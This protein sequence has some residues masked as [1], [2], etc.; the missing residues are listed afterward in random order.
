[1][2]YPQS[3]SVPAA[4]TTDMDM[5]MDM[6]MGMERRMMDHPQQPLPQPGKHA[7]AA[8]MAAAMAEAANEM[9]QQ[10]QHT[11]SFLNSNFNYWNQHSLGTSAA[12]NMEMMM[13][14]QP[15]PPPPTTNHSSAMA[16]TALRTFHPAV[17]GLGVYPSWTMV[18]TGTGTGTAAGPNMLNHQYLNHQQL[19]SKNS[20]L[21][22]Y[23]QML[24]MSY[25]NENDDRMGLFDPEMAV[26]GSGGGSSGNEP[27][28]AKPNA[29]AVHFHPLKMIED[30]LLDRTCIAN[31]AAAYEPTVIAGM[32]TAATA[33]IAC[34][35][36]STNEKVSSTEETIVVLTSQVED[37]PREENNVTTKSTETVADVIEETSTDY[38]RSKLTRGSKKKKKSMNRTKHNSSKACAPSIKMITIPS[39]FSPGHCYRA[40]A[41]YSLLRTLSIELRLSPFTFQAFTTAL[42]LPL[43]SKLLG[44]VHVRV[45]RVLFTSAGAG[46]YYYEHLGDDGG[47][48]DVIQR[49]K[50]GYGSQPGPRAK[51]GEVDEYESVKNRGGRNLSFMDQCTWPLF[52]RDYVMSTEKSILDVICATQ[53][54]S[55]GNHGGDADDEFIDLKSVAMTPLH[56]INLHPKEFSNRRRVQ[57]DDNGVG[58]NRC[59]AGPYGRRNQYGRFIC[60][61]FHISAAVQMYRKEQQQPVNMKKRSRN[62]TKTDFDGEKKCSS[63]KS[64]VALKGNSSNSSEESDDDYESDVDDSKSDD[65]YPSSTK[66]KA[67]R[68]R[69][70]CIAHK[71]PLNSFS[72]NSC[73]FQ[74]SL[75]K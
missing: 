37:P 33:T 6:D 45:L 26:V 63:R 53:S 70:A 64:S 57:L 66:K 74:K 41:A 47:V 58:I 65:D 40:A 5:D 61:P 19:S 43:P 29:T 21:E 55:N 24:M 59:P 27:S 11:S 49:R 2:Q 67:K 20:V 30:E 23:T 54:S 4:T 34:R 15:P 42:V 1:M 38:L 12:T 9:H 7:A 13:I 52:Y 36:S 17:S 69:T 28:P 3:A 46:Q 16:A 56:H 51:E 32:D 39:K 14:D 10:Q 8:A 35:P 50:R 60:C 62:S 71:G 73:K 44:E 68:N 31:T 22:S 18:G 48:L 25:T 75:T 72:T